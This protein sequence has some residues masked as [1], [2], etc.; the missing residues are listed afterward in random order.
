M[1]HQSPYVDANIHY[2]DVARSF[3][4]H[5]MSA[6]PNEQRPTSYFIGE[7]WN[8]QNHDMQL[9]NLNFRASTTSFNMSM[10]NTICSSDQ[11][12]TPH[13]QEGISQF[14]P[15]AVNSQYAGLSPNM[16]MNEAIGH[17]SI[18]YLAGYP[19]SSYDTPHDINC[20]A[21]YA[22]KSIH[23]SAHFYGQVNGDST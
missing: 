21:S 5:V 17:A 22:T 6:S 16:P 11:Y 12:M 7:T 14:Y 9:M 3:N 19:Q 23:D 13:V 8:L 10:N 20:S 2:V 4:G 1:Y 15:S 18:S